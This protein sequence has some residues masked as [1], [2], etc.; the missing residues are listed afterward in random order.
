VPEASQYKSNDLSISGCA[1]SGDVVKNFF[2]VWNASSQV[3]LQTY[4][5]PFFKSSIIGFAISE[6]FG[7]NL[8]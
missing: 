2:N 8:K 5:V 3:S 4:M 6:K 1:S 7:M